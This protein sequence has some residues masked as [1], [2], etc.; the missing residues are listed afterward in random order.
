MTK[1]KFTPKAMLPLLNMKGIDLLSMGPLQFRPTQQGLAIEVADIIQETLVQQLIVDG[2]YLLYFLA[3][4]P[5][6][7]LKRSHTPTDPFRKILFQKEVSS[8]DF[9]RYDIDRPEIFHA[10][11]LGFLLEETYVNSK[12]RSSLLRA[13][14]F[15]VDRYFH[16]FGDALHQ[17]SDPED[18][19]YLELAFES[20]FDLE[21][22]NQVPYLKQQIR[23]L[24][25]LK[26]GRPLELMWKC[27]EEFYL[28]L[29][30]VVHGG[31]PEHGLYNANPNFSLPNRILLRN[32]FLYA[33]Y[34]ALASKEWMA[35]L[36]L[37]DF[38]FL[39]IEGFDPFDL[40]VYFW[41]EATLLR[42]IS[43]LLVQVVNGAAHQDT[44]EDLHL[45]NTLWERLHDVH[46]APFFIPSEKTSLEP[47]MKI[48]APL[49]HQK[50]VVDGKEMTMAQ[51]TSSSLVHMVATF[52]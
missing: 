37:D 3:A 46:H 35:D 7:Q 24:L 19:T 38:G 16:P 48:L 45:L 39:R 10:Q 25:N 17:V 43:S 42:K 32:L 5:R 22:T 51:L 18:I 31:N 40:I 14:R 15:F 26:F 44:F 27:V 8:E 33:F 2:V 6:W 20:L 41:D 12:E 13:V 49:Q 52:F 11:A 30:D 28:Q 50:F 21:G 47:S 34:S 9:E 1:D 36:G 4:F 23:I 29:H